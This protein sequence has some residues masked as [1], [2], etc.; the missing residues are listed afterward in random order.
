MSVEPQSSDAHYGL[1]K[2]FAL[3][4]KL[5]EAIAEYQ[6]IAK[7]DPGYEGVYYD[8]GL[9]QARLRLYDDAIASFTKDK[10]SSGDSFDTE[11]ALSKVYAAKGM[12]READEA[13]RKSEHLK[14][15]Q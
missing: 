5:P 15:Q 1:G 7:L 12:Q 11:V 14:V 2:V 9:L 8:M 10:D 3:E 13:Q 4:D 6:T